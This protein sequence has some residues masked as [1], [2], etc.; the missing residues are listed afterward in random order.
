MLRGLGLVSEREMIGKAVDFATPRG[1]LPALRAW[2]GQ[3]PSLSRIMESSTSL[4]PVCS[5]VRD[6]GSK[7]G[8]EKFAILGVRP[9]QGAS[10]GQS[11]RLGPS[12]P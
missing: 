9:R 3:A 10:G 5:L 2:P 12:E 4:A 6:H 8:F 7:R 11:S 1:T